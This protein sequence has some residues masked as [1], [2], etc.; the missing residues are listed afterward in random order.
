MIKNFFSGIRGQLLFSFLIVIIISIGILIFIAQQI[1]FQ[2]FYGISAINQRYAFRLAPFFIDHYERA[3]SWDDAQALVDHWNQPLTENLS[4]EANIGFID[5]RWDIALI[6]NRVILTDKDDLVVADSQELLTTGQPLPA[7]FKQQAITLDGETGSI[8]KL[9]ILS[10]ETS[11]SVGLL[12]STSIRIIVGCGLLAAT[13][14]LIASVFLAQRIAEPLRRLSSASRRLSSGEDV[15]PLAVTGSG[16]IS[17]MTQAF[18]DMAHALEVQKHLRKQMVADIAHEL[19]TP[20]SIIQLYVEVLE[21]GLQPPQETAASLRT[22]ISALS[23]LIDDLRLLSLADTGSLNLEPELI[24]PVSFLLQLIQTWEVKAQAQQI[25]L[26]ADIAD[27]LPFFRADLGRL[28]QVMNN[29]ISNALHY[30]PVEGKVVIGGKGSGD[31]IILWISDNGPGIPAEALPHVFERFYRADPS[32]TRETGG[33]G[34]G[35][36]IARRLVMMHGGR[37][38]VESEP[39]LSTTFYITLSKA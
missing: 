22:E 1:P 2:R 16:E 36:A 9:I 7:E 20:L 28:T 15:M 3:G 25:H 5:E 10:E 34:L 35:L 14:A 11:E 4:F 23:R 32:R 39:G 13:V 17:E 26:L 6:A 27:E 21:D 30:T 33:S 24:D 37:I 18:N 8:G 31:E 29:L 19:R 38:W 12:R